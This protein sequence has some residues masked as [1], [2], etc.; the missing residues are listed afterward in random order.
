MDAD[1]EFAGESVEE[2][3]E[4][5]EEYEEESSDYSDSD[6]EGGD[7]ELSE[8]GLSWNELEKRAARSNFVYNSKIIK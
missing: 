6:V 1:S 2:A 7:E 3:D 4:E 8:E 5:E